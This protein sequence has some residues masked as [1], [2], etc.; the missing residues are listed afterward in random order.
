MNFQKNETLGYTN[1]ILDDRINWKEYPK[2]YIFKENGIASTRYLR[3]DFRNQ[4]KRDRE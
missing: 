2:P 4:K 1:V 3:H